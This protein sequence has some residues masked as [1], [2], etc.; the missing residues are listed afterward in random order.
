MITD[1]V[2]LSSLHAPSSSAERCRL[3][4]IARRAVAEVLD[5]YPG[6]EIRIDASGSV[7]GSWD[8]GRLQQAVTNLLVN[9]VQH[10]PAPARIEVRACARDKVAELAVVNNG[11]PIPE[12]LLPHVFEPF[13]HGGGDGSTGLGLF[14]VREIVRAH[15]G[16]VGVVS[17][18]VETT[19]TVRL[20]REAR[21]G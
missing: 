11:P 4:E 2:R 16:S 3:D 21:G 13:R 5:A 8:G 9:A 10:A 17:T 7:D 6:R 12:E 15:R 20:P 19:F 1:L 14:I 18:P